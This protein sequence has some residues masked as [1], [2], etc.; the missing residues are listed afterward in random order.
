MYLVSKFD[1][2]D[3]GSDMEEIFAVTDDPEPEQ[4]TSETISE[5]GLISD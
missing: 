1:S 5:E 4:P 3:E 2:D